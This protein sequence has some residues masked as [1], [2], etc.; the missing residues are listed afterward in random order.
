MK[1]DINSTTRGRE[2]ATLKP[3]RMGWGE[4]DHGCSRGEGAMVMKKGEGERR[5]QEI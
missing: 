1:I 3:Q 4:T 5:T 2:E